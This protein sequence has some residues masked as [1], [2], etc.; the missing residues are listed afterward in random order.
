MF[1]LAAG[2]SRTGHLLG[3]PALAAEGRV[4]VI[5]GL[6]AVAVLIGLVLNAALGWWWGGPGRRTGHCLLRD[7]RSPRHLRRAQLRWA[8][9]LA[10]PRS[11][12]KRVAVTVRDEPRGRLI[13]LTEGVAD[14]LYDD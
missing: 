9:Q 10:A 5:D 1:V 14:S 8:R 2:K 12:L 6:L 7:Q 13:C 4:T 11:G 3:N